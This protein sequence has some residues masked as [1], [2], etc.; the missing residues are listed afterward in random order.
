MEVML[1]L[2]VDVVEDVEEEIEEVE[3]EAVEEEDV[4]DVGAAAAVDTSAFNVKSG[5]IWA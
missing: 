5:Q 4:V 2:E 1:E 3:D